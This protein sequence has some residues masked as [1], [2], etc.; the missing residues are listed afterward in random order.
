MLCQTSKTRDRDGIHDG[1]V[2]EDYFQIFLACLRIYGCA[3]RGYPDIL[4]IAATVDEISLVV[5]PF[6]LLIVG[7]GGAVIS[8]CPFFE[9]L[10]YCR[11][12]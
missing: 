2:A 7:G 9:F 12:I 5:H 3:L 6:K 4:A 11:I 1:N 10:H 8:V